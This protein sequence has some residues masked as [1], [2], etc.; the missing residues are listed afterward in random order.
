MLIFTR[1]VGQVVYIG[2]APSVVRMEVV[3][4]GHDQVR[5]G[6]EGPAN[7]PIDREEIRALKERGIAVGDRVKHRF[8][9]RAVGK[10]VRY[11]ETG[12][13]VS[14]WVDWIEVRAGVL[15]GWFDAEELVS[16][17]R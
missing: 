16:L 14:Y 4:V 9:E 5:L 8:F 13:G 1:K 11:R 10:A 17:V 2:Q 12:R 7:M 3:S 6:F 15:N